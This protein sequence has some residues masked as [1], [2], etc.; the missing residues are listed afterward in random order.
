MFTRHLEGLRK[1]TETHDRFGTA[2]YMHGLVGAVRAEVG[3]KMVRWKD[4]QKAE[5]INKQPLVTVG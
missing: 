4:P 1:D 2:I 5:K 3:G